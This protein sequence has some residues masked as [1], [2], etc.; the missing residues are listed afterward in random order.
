MVQIDS[1]AKSVR[2]MAPRPPGETDRAEELRRYRL[3]DTPAEEPFDDLVGLAAWICDAPI[4]AVA[5]VE[6][7]RV[8]FKAKRGFVAHEA[9]RDDGFCSH[10]IAAPDTVLVVPDASRDLRFSSNPY[11][12]GEPGVRL[13][14]GAPLVNSGGRALGTLCVM[15]TVARTLADGQ[16]AALGVLGRQVMDQIEL[17]RS[18]GLLWNTSDVISLIEANTTIVH[19]TPSISRMLGRNPAEMLSRRLMDLVHPE[20]RERFAAFVATVIEDDEP[21]PVECR[22]RHRDG[23]W[24]EVETHAANASDGAEK[25]AVVLTSR[26]VTR[27]KALQARLTYETL[28]DPLTGVGN[29]TLFEDRLGQALAPRDART[30]SAGLAFVDLDDFK[31]INDTFGHRAGD[32]VLCVVADRIRQC[33]RTGDTVAR[34]GGDEFALVLEGVQCVGDAVRVAEGLLKALEQPV[35]IGDMRIVVGASVG[36]TVRDRRTVTVDGLWREAD[37]AMYAAKRNGKGSVEV[38]GG[39]RD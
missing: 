27:H 28:H 34:V 26:D 18:I 31:T 4:A 3:L 30:R 11:V 25:S 6:G 14:A 19:Q 2:R 39:L 16:V 36:I 9:A 33:L 8:W 12:V 7:D 1:C 29:R 37:I 24:V 15:D 21:G 5:L 38:F 32:H 23:H 20:D 17:R 10:V 35:A 13:Y 22:M